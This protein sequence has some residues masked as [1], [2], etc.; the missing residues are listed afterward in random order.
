QVAL[1]PAQTAID[2]SGHWE[3]AVQVP[4]KEVKI[5]VDLSKKPNG[6]LVG[7]FGQPA[8]SIKGL[9]L[10]TVAVN[11]RS[12]RFVLQA[13]ANPSTFEGSLSEDGKSISGNVTLDAYKVPF[14]LTRTG[15]ARIAPA[16]KSAA[17]GKELEGTWNSVL[18]G[19]GKRRRVILTMANQPDGT[20][21]GT[22]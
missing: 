7:T 10:S 6:D 15:D 12:V 20:S 9:P 21:S 4:E 13:D 8:Q 16:P 3:G 5:E 19:G 18:E 1:A 2:P 17:I 22:I 11:G 14:S